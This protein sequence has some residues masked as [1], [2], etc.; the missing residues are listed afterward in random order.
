VEVGDGGRL[1]LKLDL[2][3]IR[4]LDPDLILATGYSDPAM[5]P[6][7]KLLEAG[8]KVVMNTDWLEETP[9]GQAEWIKLAAAFLDRE[10]EAERLFSE[11]ERRYL[12][13]AA[14]TRSLAHRPTVLTGT[15]HR[16]TWYVPGGRSFIA[17]YIRDAGG[18][19]LWQDD[20]SP[21]SRMMNLE[22]VLERGR[23]ADF[24]LIYMNAV[25]S[26]RDLADS[27]DRCALFRSFREGQVYNNDLR[28]SAGGGNDFYETG[29]YRPDLV[30]GDLVAVLHP[31]LE[32]GHAF[33]WYRR[34]P[35]AR[36]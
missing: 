36:P 11:V 28:L 10:D 8:F 13:L 27:D 20:L 9:L 30:L 19:Y 31:E 14:R 12:A 26:L 4:V 16:G 6:N 24:W 18:S 17:A 2:E 7:G 5:D 34:L 22:A 32:P 25:G 21:A 23:D 15:E 35:A 29:V 33:T 1:D 3:R